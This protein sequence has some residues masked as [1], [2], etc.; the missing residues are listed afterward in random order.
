MQQISFHNELFY[1]HTEISKNH[2]SNL[3]NNELS[4][5]VLNLNVFKVLQ[6]ILLLEHLALTYCGPIM[7]DVF[8]ILA[9]D[10]FM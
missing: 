3:I 1:C 8:F 7:K 10:C 6:W 5:Y 2:Q 9:M 4:W